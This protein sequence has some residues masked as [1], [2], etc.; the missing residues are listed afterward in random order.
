MMKKSKAFLRALWQVSKQPLLV[1][2]TGL[3]VAMVPPFGNWI[4]ARWSFRPPPSFRGYQPTIWPNW[5]EPQL[6]GEWVG[7]GLI[8][9]VIFAVAIGLAVLVAKMNALIIQCFI[10]SLEE[11]YRREL[12]IVEK[13]EAQ[14]GAVTLVEEP[15]ESPV[16]PSGDVPGNQP[17]S[18]WYK[19]AGA[20]HMASIGADLLRQHP[21]SMWNKEPLT[22]AQRLLC[23][24]AIIDVQQMINQI[25]LFG[26][27]G[28]WRRELVEL[29]FLLERTTDQGQFQA[30]SKEMAR[31]TSH[32]S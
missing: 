32:R 7:Y 30:A 10:A 8:S 23:S 4:G 17:D 22:E 6:V 11:Q 24:Q 20:R 29:K 16:E 18:E 28:A 5:S 21:S 1:V 27:D 15:S 12:R 9:S 13:A 25:D 14:G 3:F 2:A 26:A 19:P 31:L